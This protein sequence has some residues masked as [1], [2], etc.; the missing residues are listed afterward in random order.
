MTIEVIR[1]DY[2]N[3]QHAQ[4]VVM[5]LNEYAVDP[6]GGEN[7]FLTIQQSI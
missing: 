6:M 2:N 1:A 7:R 4:D 3:E 5:L